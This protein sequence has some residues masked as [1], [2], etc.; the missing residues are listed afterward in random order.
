MTTA[1]RP[2]IDLVSTSSYAHGH[3]WDQYAWLR[4]NDP[5]HWHEEPDGPGFWAITKYQDIRD[6]SRRPKLFSSYRRGVMMGEADD[7]GLAAQRLMM[8]TDGPA[9]A[10]PVQAARE[11]GLQPG[12]APPP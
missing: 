12:R 11:P 2:V 9:R 6:I 1:T 10:R 8:L 7:A 5:V 4:A 3:P